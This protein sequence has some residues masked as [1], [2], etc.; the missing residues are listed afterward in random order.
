M[1]L[2]LL[3][4]TPVVSSFVLS[5]MFQRDH[6]AT[7]PGFEIITGALPRRLIVDFASPHIHPGFNLAR[8]TFRRMWPCQK[9]TFHIT[10]HE[11]HEYVICLCVRGYVYVFTRPRSAHS[12]ISRK[13]QNREMKQDAY[14]YS[15]VICFP[16]LDIIAIFVISY[17]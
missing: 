7:V 5:C 4:V 13:K 10:F 3:C 14:L 8:M 17:I 16:I 1:I 2:F 6:E 9:T 15:R 12:F 11:R